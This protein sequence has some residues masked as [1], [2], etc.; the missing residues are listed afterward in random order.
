MPYGLDIGGTKIATT[1]FDHR[2]QSCST[3]RVSTPTE[4]YSA[5]LD[6]VKQS[7]EEAG[8]RYQCKGT[9][10]IGIPG[11]KHPKTQQWHISNIPAAHNRPL[12][13]DLEHALQR[14]VQLENDG[15]CFTLSEATGGAGGGYERV[16]GV[17]MGTG[18]GGSLCIQKKL[19]EGAQGVAG[20]WGHTA[21]SARI[22][23]KYQFPLLDCGCGLSGCVEQY[24]AGP[25]LSRLYRFFGGDDL[26]APDIVECYRQ[27]EFR[28]Q[29][30]FDALVDT[31]ASA[32][33]HLVLTIDP[34]VIVIGGG[35]SQVP[36]LF[37][38]LPDAMSSYL[39]G[40]LQAPLIASPEFGDDSGVRGAAILGAQQTQ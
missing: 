15:R 11:A 25:G 28:A 20:E 17:I 14:P 23:Q 24:I 13:T 5:F 16:F 21:L 35:L 37:E 34:D 2:F 9:V 27:G 31:A 36:E 38:Q 33:S 40:Q 19:Y 3:E 30:A 22:L 1:V 18:V 7:V 26:S 12:K 8:R 32:M 10:G 39:F 6:A 29:Q 4:D